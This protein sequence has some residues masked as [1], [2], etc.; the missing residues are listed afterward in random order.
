[1]MSVAIDCLKRPEGKTPNALRREGLVPV[2]IYGHKGAESDAMAVKLQDAATLLRA[3]AVNRTVVE[4]RAPEL[5]WQGKALIREAQF[6]PWKS[7]LYHLS[8][9]VVDNQEKVNTVVPIR[10]TGESLV[11]KQ[12]GKMRQA[13]K[14][15]KVQCPPD[16]IPEEITIDITELQAGKRV[17]VSDL[18]LPEG[19]ETGS[20]GSLTVLAISN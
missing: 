8:F 10:L 12:G 11:V 3:V 13:I 2:T 16:R 15:I 6:H 17:L 9:F 1:M 4:V 20:M 7:L 5:N 14:A 19:V 18:Q